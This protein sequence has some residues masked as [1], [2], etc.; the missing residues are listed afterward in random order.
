MMAARGLGTRQVYVRLWDRVWDRVS[1]PVAV[2]STAAWSPG[3]SVEKR[4]CVDSF[5]EERRFSAASSFRSTSGFSPRPRDPIFQLLSR[6]QVKA[7]SG[8]HSD[9]IHSQDRTRFHDAGFPHQSGNAHSGQ[10]PGSLLRNAPFRIT[11]VL[12]GIA[13]LERSVGAGRTKDCPR[14]WGSHRWAHAGNRVPGFYCSTSEFVIPTEG[15]NLLPLA[16]PTNLPMQPRRSRQRPIYS[17]GATYSFGLAD[18]SPKKN[19]S[20]CFTMTS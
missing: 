13:T 18:P 17:F 5:V 12:G 11:L 9:D 14:G 2:R 8:G 4:R 15:R 6:N 3:S 19:I 16:G 7:R 10:S 1:D 20:I